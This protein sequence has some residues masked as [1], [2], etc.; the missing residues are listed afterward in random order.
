[1]THLPITQ[2]EVLPVILACATWGTEWQHV[3]V[4]VHWDNQ[5]AGAVL[6]SDYSKDVFIMHL[7]QCAFFIRALLSLDNPVAYIA[8]ADNRLVDF[9]SWDNIQAYFSQV[10]QASPQPT[11]VPAKLLA[12]LTVD[13][14]D[15]PSVAWTK[16]FADSFQPVSQDILPPRRYSKEIQLLYFYVSRFP[17]VFFAF[18]YTLNLHC[19][20]PNPE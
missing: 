10:P 3:Q 1:M 18:T 2:K 5:A 6:N 16:S 9:I 13:Q 12:L 7:L 4:L 15:R 8:G 20:I 17:Q 19:S 14:P 11:Q